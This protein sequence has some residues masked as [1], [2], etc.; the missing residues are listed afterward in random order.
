M[1]SF[2]KRNADASYE[3]GY[4]IAPAHT[5]RGITTHAVG[6]VLDDALHQGLEKL[7]AET[8][9]GNPASYRV[10]EKNG[11]HPVGTRDDPEDGLVSCWARALGR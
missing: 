3:V 11:F 1:V 7:T 10:L 5:G 6:L 2:T 8:S 9:V 4:G